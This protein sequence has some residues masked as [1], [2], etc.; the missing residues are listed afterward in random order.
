MV[1]SCVL[2]VFDV[3]GQICQVAGRHFLFLVGAFQVGD[4]DLEGLLEGFLL[5]IGDGEL[6]LFAQVGDVCQDSVAASGVV[7]LGPFNRK[8]GIDSGLDDVGSK[9][10]LDS[11]G[12]HVIG[13]SLSGTF[14]GGSDEDFVVLESADLLLDEGQEPGSRADTSGFKHKCQL[15]EDIDD[16]VAQESNR[17]ASG[18]QLP[19]DGSEDGGGDGTHKTQVEHLLD[20]IRDAED[21]V[22]DTNFNV[23]SGNTGNDEEASSDG[24]LATAHESGKVLSSV[25]EKAVASLQ[26]KTGRTA[27][28]LGKLGD[29]EESNLH[30]LEKSNTAHEDKEENEGDGV[31]ESFPGGGLSTVESFNGNGKGKSKNAKGEKDASPEEDQCDPGFRRL[32][33]FD[34]LSSGPVSN[35][36]DQIRSVHDTGDLNKSSNP[37][38][39]GHEVVVDVVKHAVRSIDLRSQLTDGDVLQDHGK[40]RAEE[41]CGNPV[42]EIED[43]SAC[44]RSSAKTNG[45]VNE[46]NHELTSHEVSVEV[47][48][49]VSPSGDLVGDRVGFAVEFSVDW[50]KTDHGALSSFDHRHPDDKSP[51]DETCGSWVNITGQL[52]VSGGNQGQDGD[53]REGQKEQGNDDTNPIQWS[54]RS[55][56]SSSRH[57]EMGFFSDF[58]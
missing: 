38:G 54:V 26:S 42:R 10:K 40:P 14:F 37:V 13:G 9:V 30:T 47:V 19:C 27:F 35:H 31:R 48:S 51:H 49:L 11:G 41:D 22:I 33:G 29:G 24:H 6:D 17:E 3:H 1:G 23:N 52:G 15:E 57:L 45:E 50:G 39:E 2:R 55:V 12:I 43:I 56:R 21:V 7:T 18:N 36:T 5:D 28:R 4:F 32:V 34:R 53:D 44:K 16:R 58:F 20:R 25:L 8:S 46:D